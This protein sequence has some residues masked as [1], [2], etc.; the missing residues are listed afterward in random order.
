MTL[1][2]FLSS[3]FHTWTITKEVMQMDQEYDFHGMMEFMVAGQQVG[4]PQC[5]GHGKM[6]RRVHVV[7]RDRTQVGIKAAPVGTGVQ[8]RRCC[9]CLAKSVAQKE[10]LLTF[11]PQDQTGACPGS[12]MP[13]HVQGGCSSAG[14]DDA[15]VAELTPP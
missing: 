8:C 13:V 15:D 14:S 4:L 11:I 5:H 7:V 3:A 1:H 10:H 12:H 9:T 2:P 6:P